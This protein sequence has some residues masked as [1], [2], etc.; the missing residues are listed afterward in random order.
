M[1]AAVVAL[2]TFAGLF[3]VSLRTNFLGGPERFAEITIGDYEDIQVHVTPGSDL[4]AV[5]EEVADTEGVRKVFATGYSDSSSIEGRE[6][7]IRVLNDFDGLDYSSVYE[8]RSPRH[9]NEIAIGSQAARVYDTGVGDT[10][11]VTGSSGS[12]DYLVVG[13]VQSVSGIGFL[14]QL[15][16]EGY[17]RID[18]AYAPQDLAVYVDDTTQIDQVLE[19]LRSELGPEVS[20]IANYAEYMTAATQIYVSMLDVMSWGILAVTVLVIIVVVTFASASTLTDAM[21]SLGIRKALGFTATNLLVQLV[22]MA[23]PALFMG[24][25]IGWVLSVIGVD[26]LMTAM[27]GIAGIARIDLVTQPVLTL[28]FL[29]L[30]VTLGL[31]VTFLG[32]LRVRRVTPYALM[33]E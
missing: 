31:L 26:R 12:R 14:S 13:F 4:N 18:K 10:I 6:V 29:V 32:A 5:E 15:T 11:T 24:V 17:Q 3:A 27:L 7:P 33:S 2:V 25:I 1:V 9:A 23:G 30:I 8:G 19:S 22:A 20:G 16:T 21:S 28:G